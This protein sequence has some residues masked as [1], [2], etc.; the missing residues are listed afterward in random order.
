[1]EILPKSD[2]PPISR[3]LCTDNQQTIIVAPLGLAIR[4]QRRPAQWT[5][6]V[7][8]LERGCGA[9]PFL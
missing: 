4:A 5:A 7:I 3:K 1:M 9:H 6:V 2:E 8:E